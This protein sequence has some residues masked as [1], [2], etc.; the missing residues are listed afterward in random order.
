VH[1]RRVEGELS[2]NSGFKE[3]AAAVLSPPTVL[4]LSLSHR[5]FARCVL[6]E[7]AWA[8]SNFFKL[9]RGC[10]LRMHLLPFFKLLG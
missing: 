1:A 9:L 2:P 10:V 6:K 5:P 3:K 8:L 7:F 4:V